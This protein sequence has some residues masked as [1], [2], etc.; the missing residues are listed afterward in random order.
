MCVVF[1]DIESFPLLKIIFVELQKYI[2]Y[3]FLYVYKKQ[4]VS[5]YNESRD[6]LYRAIY[7]TTLQCEVVLLQQGFPNIYIFH[8]LALSDDWKYPSYI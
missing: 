7:H 2:V 1:S 8:I 5:L 3:G 6:T 4:W